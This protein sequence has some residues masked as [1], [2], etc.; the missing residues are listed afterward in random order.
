MRFRASVSA[1]RSR[2]RSSR[3][4]AARSRAAE[5]EGAGTTFVVDL[6]LAAAR[7]ARRLDRTHYNPAAND[8]M[9]RLRS[10]AELRVTGPADAPAAVVCVNG[11]QGGEVEGTWSASLEWLVRRLA[12]RFPRLAFGEVRYRIKSWKRLDWCVEDARAAIDALGAPRTLL[13]GF[14]MGGAVAVQAA[15]RAVGRDGA[16]PRA[17]VPRPAVARA[18]PRP[19]AARR[20]TARSTAGCPASPAS[21]PR[22]RAAASSGRARSASRAS[23][24]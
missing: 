13:L 9:E 24:R 4:T 14:S 6:P 16:R 18:A 19:A 1:S 20:C 21:R 2:R 10:G 12:P 3:R 8:R 5:R 17:V 15:G 7:V 23:T 22:A 11:G